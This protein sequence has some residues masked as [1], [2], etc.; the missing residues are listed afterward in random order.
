MVLRCFSKLKMVRTG[1]PALRGSPELSASRVRSAQLARPCFSKLKM[2]K[3]GS[4]AL[5]D[6]PVCRGLPV[7]RARPHF[8][9]RSMVPMARM[10]Y[11]FR[12]HQA[13]PAL[14][15]ELALLVLPYFLKPR[16]VK[17]V[18]PAPPAS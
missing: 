7:L 4:P 5:R 9:S 18:N 13:Y 6:Q 12:G 14:L 8:Q 16:M 1:K 2:V 17:M 15:V 3:M 11:L 10:E